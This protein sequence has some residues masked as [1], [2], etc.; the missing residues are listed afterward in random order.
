MILFPAV[1]TPPLEP[2]P[3]TWHQA[4]YIFHHHRYT[5]PQHAAAAA[6]A[7]VR[8]CLLPPAAVLDQLLQRPYVVELRTDTAWIKAC[9]AAAAAAAAA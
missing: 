8:R 9:G 6:A 1:K 3:R 4:C 5:P 2:L 7:A